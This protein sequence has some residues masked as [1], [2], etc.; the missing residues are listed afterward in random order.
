MRSIFLGCL[1]L[2]AAPLACDREEI[3]DDVD[4]T[5]IEEVHP[6]V[7]MC[8]EMCHRTGMMLVFKSQVANGFQIQE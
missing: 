8:R 1:V 2:L 5:V 3:R 7:Q 6:A 4:A